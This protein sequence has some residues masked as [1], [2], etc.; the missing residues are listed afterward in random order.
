MTDLLSDL[1]DFGGAIPLPRRQVLI[2][3][4]GFY[5]RITPEQYFMEPCPKPALTNSG[6]KIILNRPAAEFAE[7]HPALGEPAEQVLQNLL[8]R[9]GD[10]VHQLALNKGRGYRVDYS[11]K[12]WDRRNAETAEYLDGCLRDGV[13]PIKEKDFI[14]AEKMALQ[15]QFRIA[16][17][18]QA[19]G[20]RQGRPEPVGGWAYETEVVAACTFDVGGVEIWV[21]CMMD[22]WCEDLGVILDPKITKFIYDDKVDSHRSN[23]N[24][25]MQ[26]ALYKRV[27]AQILPETSGRLEFGNVLMNPDAPFRTRAVGNTEAT[28]HSCEME[29]DRAMVK[30]A[31]H[32][33]A[34]KWPDFQVD[35]ERRQAPNWVLKQRMEAEIE[36]EGE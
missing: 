23:M 22:V 9:R 29:I 30:F 12:K 6:I 10:V 24:W 31:G 7:N 4:P 21:R 11:G 25:D 28:N 2:T 18:L 27:V 15:L 34:N 13:T 5:P 16:L 19:I 17:T 33:T 32:L 20:K 35:I 36:E 3:A 14:E 8:K 26:E 1:P